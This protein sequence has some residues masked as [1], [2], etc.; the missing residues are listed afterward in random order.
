MV[1]SSL[2]SYLNFYDFILK[3]V[4]F[5]FTGN[6]IFYVLYFY[7]KQISHLHSE[8]SELGGGGRYNP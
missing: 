6:L 1:W 2:I 8:K 5:L 7:T 3:I 4:S